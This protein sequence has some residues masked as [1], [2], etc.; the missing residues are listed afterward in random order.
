MGALFPQR[1][2]IGRT[3]ERCK[4]DF[5][6]RDTHREL[7]VLHRDLLKLRREDPAIRAAADAMTPA[8][9]AVDSNT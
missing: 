4:L 5:S 6:E 1:A 2:Q 9:R 3:F 7:Y 8:R